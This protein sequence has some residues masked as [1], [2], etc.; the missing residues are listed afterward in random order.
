MEMMY[1]SIT[2]WPNKSC[3]WRIVANTSLV[4]RAVSV[5]GVSGVD[6]GRRPVSKD[7]P[8]EVNAWWKN[9]SFHN[10]ADHALSDD[11]RGALAELRERGLAHRTAVMC[12]EAVWWRCHRRFIA[13][14]LLAHDEDVRH[15]LG[16]NH[17]DAAQ[18]SLGAVIDPHGVVTYPATG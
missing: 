15:I 5:N 7:V 14:H 17:I 13:D 6:S 8:F 4:R 10:Y 3:A 18:L 16:G 12:S 11:F 9:R 2:C 1:D